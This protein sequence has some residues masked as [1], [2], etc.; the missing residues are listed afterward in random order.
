[1][2]KPKMNNKYKNTSISEHQ[3]QFFR[4][5]NGEFYVDKKPH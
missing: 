1:M 2:L 5:G 3:P 4:C